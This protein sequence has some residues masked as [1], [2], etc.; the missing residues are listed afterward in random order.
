VTV[1]DGGSTPVSPETTYIARVKT[2]SRSGNPVN[3]S[4]SL[5]ITGSATT[6]NEAPTVPVPSCSVVNTTANCSVNATDNGGTSHLFYHW[7]VVPAPGVGIVP[8]DVLNNNSTTITFPSNGAYQVSVTV[9]DH[10]GVGGLS[11]TNQTPVNIGQT[12]TSITV[13]P[14]S[15]TIA[16]G[17]TGSFTATV[18]DQ[19]NAIIPNASVNWSKSG[20]GDGT[21]SSNFSSSTIFTA[22]TP[23]SVTLTA[24]L[25]G[26]SNGIAS[27]TVLASGVQW[28]TP[29]SLTLTSST[30]GMASARGTD[31]V[32]GPGS[33]NYTWS[34]QSGPAGAA[35]PTLNCTNGNN[36]AQD[37]ALTFHKAGVYVMRVVL[38]NSNGSIN[39]VTPSTTVVQVL[40]G[41][42]VATPGGQ[43]DIT[44]KTF[45]DVQF[46]AT[47]LDQFADGMSNL[48]PV[49]WSTT[50]G[51]ISGS[52]S[53]VNFNSPSLGQRVTVTARVGL[54]SA[55]AFVSLV[56]YDVS[57][58]IAYPVPYKSTQG[59]GTICFRQLG[60][61]A[62]I[63]IYT[64]SGRK[65]FETEVTPSTPGG[66][67][68][69]WNVKN[70]SGE[71]VA[72]GVYFY[73]IESQEG[74]KNGKLIIIQ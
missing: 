47:G 71:N 46:V 42:R 34:L 55:S 45:T 22:T 32:L 65:V 72:S 1:N 52:G 62:T 19:F 70:S 40:S 51:N 48:P 26:A 59:N 7:A 38:S 13:N 44:A 11:N 15:A 33:V 60:S 4:A 68:Y 74:K 17:L 54:F 64:A 37:C 20:T 21:L 49:Q 50:G 58:A 6:P 67:E 66:C 24:S 10:D 8:N 61:Q 53:Q 12:P 69:P 28:V 31:N 5:S 23:G 18:R 30:Q 36:A 57:G 56:S 29:P 39:D 25:P 43:T 3:D 41:L 73:V 63:R 35:D 9:T 14:N 27:I 2:I 16:T